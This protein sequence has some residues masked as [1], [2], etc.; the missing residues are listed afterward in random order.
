MWMIHKILHTDKVK[1]K[2]DKQA[3]Q[4]EKDKKHIQKL[5]ARLEKIEK[6]YKIKVDEKNEVK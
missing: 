1:A 4:V 3:K 6:K 2:A 5:N